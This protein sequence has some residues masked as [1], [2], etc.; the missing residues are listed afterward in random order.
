MQ[1]LKKNE[2][3][4]TKPC[5]KGAITQWGLGALRVTLVLGVSWGALVSTAPVALA[6]NAMQ[7][8]AQAYRYYEQG[9]TAFNQGNNALATQ[10]FEQATAVDATFNDA[11]FN[12]GSVYFRAGLYEKAAV[13]FDRLTRL[14][15]GD[16]QAQFNL[17]LALEK[18]GRTDEA[19]RAFQ[20]IAPTAPKFAAAQERLAILGQKLGNNS[21]KMLVAQKPATLPASKPA[22]NAST[23]AM[24]MPSKTSKRFA[25]SLSGP[26]GMALGP[27]GEVYVA[28]YSQHSVVKIT[29]DG[30]QSILV[31]DKGLSGPIGLVRD[32]RT[33][34]FYVA[35]YLKGDVVMITPTGATSSLATGLKKPYSLLL[36]SL[37]NVLYVTEQGTNSVSQIQL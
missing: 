5:V 25:A 27:M 4:A 10:Y 11:W 18:L 29:P 33:G 26:T 9:I 36:D 13:A 12:L 8:K 7:T 16:A 2:T 32:P 35:N 31:K 6:Q 14:S 3:S 1:W 19:M 34:N 22:S 20:K 23:P 30:K 37:S 24:A 17:G 21:S 28:N 15:P